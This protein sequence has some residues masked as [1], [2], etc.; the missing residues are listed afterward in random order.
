MNTK[1]FHQIKNEWRSNLWLFAEL[2]L[3]SVILWFAV[4]FLYV[5]T[6][7]KIQP[8]GY[9]IS[10]CY[11]ISMRTLPVGS[12]GYVPSDTL[13]YKDFLE[14]ASRL[15]KRSDVEYVGLS[16]SESSPYS[17]SY[18][19]SMVEYGKFLTE[20]GVAVRR[21]YQQDFF[22]V[23]KYKGTHGET[24]E[25]LFAMI[26]D[27]KHCLLS[28]NVVLKDTLKKGIIKASALVGKRIL[29]GGDSMIV[30]GTIVNAKRT[31]FEDSR[32]NG[33]C[34]KAD[35]IAEAGNRSGYLE[36]PS[37]TIRVK[38]DED[39]DFI[40]KLW[41]DVD[42]YYKIGN[43]FITNIESFKD[44]RSN[45]ALDDI[46]QERI[47]TAALLFLLINIFLGLLGTFW[48]RTQQRSSEIALLKAIG[49]DN[50]SIF[51]RQIKEGILLLTFATIPAIIID[52]NLAYIPIVP[53]LNGVYLSASRLISCV[54]V[55]YILMAIVIILGIWMPARKA[56]KIQPAAA[57]HED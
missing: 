35:N 6:V 15:G 32:E 2:L 19:G 40:N 22:K 48:F 24:P 44:V 30:A 45:F 55:T 42:K 3:V 33:C 39:H 57:L 43:L 51:S 1:L 23:F 46:N 38:P 27:R 47:Y 25:Q 26:A 49:A 54:L 4:D 11:Q 50:R 8:K 21:V 13:I 41:K 36:Y 29:F 52:A 18:M 7:V 56:M 5:A 37:L 53:A 28:D 14:L 10:H 31:D 17:G 16:G 34:I 12:V 20:M 9:D